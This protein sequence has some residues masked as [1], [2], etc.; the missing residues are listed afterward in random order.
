M[1]FQKQNTVVD[2]TL[3]NSE[4]VTGQIVRYSENTGK[5]NVILMDIQ[6]PV[7]NDHVAKLIDIPQVLNTIRKKSEEVRVYIF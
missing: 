4:K 3:N 2:I 1:R 7:M 6:M 5:Y